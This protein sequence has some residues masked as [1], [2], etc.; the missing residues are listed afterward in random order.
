MKIRSLSSA[1]MAFLFAFPAMTSAQTLD[2]S[3]PL[4]VGQL[5]PHGYSPNQIFAQGMVYEPLVKYQADGT[6]AP[7]LA[8]SWTV[9]EDGRTYTFKLRPGVT[10]SNGEPFNAAAV[11]LNLDTVIAQAADHNWLGLVGVLKS[12]DVVDDL[13]VDI[14][15]TDPYYPL[16]QEM[17]LI[18]P[19]RFMAPAGFPESGNTA[20]GIV[21]PIGTGPWVL[22][23]T[24]LG[25][26]DTFTRN[27]TYWGKA[28]AFEKVNI[29]V[30]ADPNTRAI[31]LET[32]EIDLIYGS[33]GQITPDTFQRLK[34]A[35][36]ESGLSAPFETLALALHTG[37][38]PTDDLAVRRAINHAIDKDAII[39]GIFYGTQQ[40]ADTLFPA[41]LPYSDIG[42]AP[43]AY[44]PQ[45][46]A[47][48]LG[49][50]TASCVPPPVG[51][52]TAPRVRSGQSTAAFARQTL[53][54]GTC[55]FG[56][57]YLF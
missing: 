3:W 52:P 50:Q 44:D 11:K 24:V 40:K 32:G 28:P 46:A 31:A 8:E 13:T 10:F 7:W 51:T 9:S 21:A 29:K 22:T 33:E 45:A 1:A 53:L 36:Y 16:L 19:V 54:I 26:Y 35:G 17:A 12:I 43:Y 49:H 2:F 15:T 41:T 6:V 30:I 14:T 5:N 34:D 42:L 18:R 4:N 47:A 37:K 20:D 25:Q 55:S 48:L 57:K 39:K 27:E 56:L 23:E 38:A